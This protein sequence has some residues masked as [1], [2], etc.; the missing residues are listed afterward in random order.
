MVNSVALLYGG[1]SGEHDVSCISAQF[2]EKNILTA[3]YKVIPVYIDR[4]G[5]WHLQERVH[6]NPEKNIKRPVR[7]VPGDPPELVNE[8][9]SVTFDF[10]FP[11]IHGTGGEDGTLQGLL[12]FFR[13]PYA[14]AGVLCSSLCMDKYFARQMF[15]QH[16]LPQVQYTRISRSEWENDSNAVEDKISS[17]FAYPVFIKPCRMGSSVGVHKVAHENE[18]SK[19]IEEALQYDD[20]LLCEEGKNVRELEISILGNYPDYQVSQI[21]EIE[22]NHN[23]YSYEAKYLDKDGASLTIPAQ[24]TEKEKQQI[25]SMALKAFAATSGDGFARIDFFMDK[26]NGKILLNEIN[27][28]P[29]FTPVSMFPMLWLENGLDGPSLI[30]KIIDLGVQKFH[31]LSLLS[32]KR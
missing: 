10:V 4:H 7:L 5:E 16:D 30:Q 2:I 20:F 11:I 25:Q 19:A 29:G 32:V 9:E 31:N 24:I 28:L 23:F 14:G 17:N 27:T 26:A 8:N 6:T 12:D 18:I 15:N 13:I 21:G 22:P 3:G 1:R